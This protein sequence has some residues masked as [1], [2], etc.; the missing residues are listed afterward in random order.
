MGF[1]VVADEVRNLAQQSVPAAKD[2][3][4][5]IEESIQ[6]SHEGRTR[7]DVVAAVTRCVIE[8]RA[9]AKT[10]IEQVKVGSAEQR[11]GIEQVA[12]AIEHLHA[13]TERTALSSTEGAN[14]SRELTAQSSSLQEAVQA[15]HDTVGS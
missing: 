15:L 5:L 9:S 7:F 14:S 10:L 1:A 13:A 4:T 6:H 2:T 3:A 12:A 8:S 11:R